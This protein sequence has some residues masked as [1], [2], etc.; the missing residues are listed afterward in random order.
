[1]GRAWDKVYACVRREEVRPDRGRGRGVGTG[2][3]VAKGEFGYGDVARTG[4]P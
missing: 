1:M 2:V 3:E 4:C